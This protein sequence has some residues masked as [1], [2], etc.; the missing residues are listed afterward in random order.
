MKL[1]SW[2]D[3]LATGIDI[4][5]EQ[6]RRLVDLV[7][8]TAPSLVS[9]GAGAA[10]DAGPLSEQ[11]MDYAKTH[12]RTEEDLMLERGVDDRVLDHHRKA[13]A[14]FVDTVGSIATRLAAGEGIAGNELLSFLAGWLISHLLGEDQTLARQIRAIDA[15]LSPD[16]A[17][18]EAGGYRFSP[19]EAALTSVL[20][21]LYS[22][23]LQ[24]QAPASHGKADQ[25]HDNKGDGP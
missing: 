13:H 10:P 16:R 22:Q 14:A 1:M 20:I 12:F 18:R 6:H 25:G 4:L 15:G 7:N 8:A 23:L 19:S 5:D 17:Y 9:S 2:N 21:D 3:H 11:L 24:Y